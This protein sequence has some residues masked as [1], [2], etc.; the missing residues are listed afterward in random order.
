MET[1]QHSSTEFCTLFTLYVMT[2]FGCWMLEQ[3]T[4]SRRASKLLPTCLSWLMIFTATVPPL[5]RPAHAIH[6]SDPPTEDQI[7]GE[8][9]RAAP[10]QGVGTHN[11]AH[12]SKCPPLYTRPK[13]PRPMRGPSSRASRPA[14]ERC[15]NKSWMPISEPSFPP[16]LRVPVPG[17]P[18]STIR[19]VS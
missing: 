18:A 2:T 5:Q 7:A 15:R 12:E 13:D 6:C 19:G 14:S 16:V 8:T 10:Q 17:V 1:F 3:S 4:D 11:R 9:G